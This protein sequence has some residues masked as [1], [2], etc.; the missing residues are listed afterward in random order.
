MVLSTLGGHSAYFPEKGT[1]MTLLPLTSAE[2]N[3]L[4]TDNPNQI[5]ARCAHVYEA[6]RDHL[7]SP[8]SCVADIQEIRANWL[9]RG[10]RSMKAFPELLKP[11][12]DGG[13]WFSYHSG[14]RLEAQF[15]IAMDIKSF[16]VGI[17]FHCEL[18]DR[19]EQEQVKRAFKVFRDVVKLHESEFRKFVKQNGLEVRWTG[20]S[21]GGRKRTRDVVKWLKRGADS[22]DWTW[23]FVGKYLQ[24]REDKATLENPDK[25][26]KVIESVFSGFKPLWEETQRSAHG[27]TTSSPHVAVV[28]RKP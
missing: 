7:N 26:S 9:R 28:R 25:L 18:E 22:R 1:V 21:S 14:G 12:K 20:K 6:F 27:R 23:V 10:P 13:H 4:K 5:V 3:A 15:N 17:G 11:W 8:A 19:E 2:F 16:R 24:R